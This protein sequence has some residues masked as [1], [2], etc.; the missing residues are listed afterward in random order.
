MTDEEMAKPSFALYTGSETE[1]EREYMRLI[2]NGKWGE[3]PTS[4]STKLA[5][6][7]E[8]NEMGDIIKVLMI[9]PNLFNGSI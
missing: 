6:Y 9:I 7:A 3:I 4:L 8:N 5:T 2:Y 1:E